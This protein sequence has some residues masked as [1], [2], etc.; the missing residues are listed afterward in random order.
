MPGKFAKK[1][2]NLLALLKFQTEEYLRWSEVNFDSS[3]VS[4]KQTCEADK[5]V[6]L[7]VDLS[8]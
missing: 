8:S 5:A 7:W 2:K 1:K 6:C 3:A 4:E